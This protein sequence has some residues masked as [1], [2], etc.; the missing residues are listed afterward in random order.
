[1]WP[2]FHLL[3]TFFE[4]AVRLPFANFSH[5]YRIPLVVVVSGSGQPLEFQT[6]ISLYTFITTMTMPNMGK[7]MRYTGADYV[8]IFIKYCYFDTKYLRR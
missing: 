7:K 2:D 8:N 1:M 4:L 3:T 5:H 6:K